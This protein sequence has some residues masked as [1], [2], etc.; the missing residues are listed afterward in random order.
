MAT[1]T[2]RRNSSF[3]T[4]SET[5]RLWRI[6]EAPSS[7]VTETGLALIP[8]LI[9]LVNAL[10]SYIAYL[11]SPIGQVSI[12]NAVDQSKTATNKSATVPQKAGAVFFM[13][14]SLSP[15]S[16][17]EGAGT[18]GAGGKAVAKEVEE[19]VAEGGSGFFGRKGFELSNSP[20]RAVRNA[21]A[22]IN[23][24]RYSGHALDQMQN[25]GIVPSVVERTLLTQ[26]PQGPQT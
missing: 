24:I 22:T 10:D 1:E 23:G 2:G 11:S 21:P 4:R 16:A 14:L 20:L 25:R 17:G 19:Q 5:R 15:F 18:A 6:S 9:Q 26:L 3:L 13:G 7:I 12:S 8:Y